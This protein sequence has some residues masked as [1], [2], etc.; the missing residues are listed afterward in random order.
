MAAH[1]AQLVAAGVT[2]V[3]D[4]VALGDLRDGGSRHENLDKMIKYSQLKAN[5]EG[6][7]RAQHLLHLRCEVPHQSTLEIFQ[8]L[9]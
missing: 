7:N 4:A 9:C 3:L 8:C 6:V 5:N 1:D 2:T